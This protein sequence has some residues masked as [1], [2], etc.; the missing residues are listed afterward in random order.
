M[1]KAVLEKDIT[2]N[3]VMKFY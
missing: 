1:V 2:S 3:I